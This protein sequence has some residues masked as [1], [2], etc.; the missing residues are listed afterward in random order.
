LSGWNTPQG[1]IED[2]AS[3][4]RKGGKEKG[5]DS[6]IP[7]NTLN[8]LL[9]LSS[10]T[11]VASCSVFFHPQQNFSTTDIANRPA[12]GKILGIPTG[13]IKTIAG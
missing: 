8:V 10:S 1:G 7:K 3:F 9:C 4:R 13:P 5:G 2:P 6:L 11:F 12:D